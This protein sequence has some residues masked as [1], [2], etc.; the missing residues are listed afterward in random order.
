MSDEETALNYIRALSAEVHTSNQLALAR[1]MFARPY[2]SLSPLEQGI[3]NRL[4]W[5]MM[6]S[7]Y[8]ALLPS[9]FAAPDQQSEPP[10]GNPVGFQM[11]PK[12]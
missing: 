2:N 3:V 7:N 6:W 12:D 4:A 9:A 11:P 5:D 1:D 8:H 10:P